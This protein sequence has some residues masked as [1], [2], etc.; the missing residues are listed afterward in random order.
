[1]S[2]VRTPNMPGF[3]LR[4]SPITFLQQFTR[5]QQPHHSNRSQKGLYANRDVN[6]G[7]VVTFSAKKNRRRWLPNVQR[8]QLWSEMLNK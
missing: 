7:N 2:Y 6:Y 8:K 3:S 4:R 1:M 5:K